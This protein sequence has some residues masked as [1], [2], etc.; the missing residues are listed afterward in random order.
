DTVAMRPN[1][2]GTKAEP[3]VLPARI[4]NLLVNGATGI[5]VGM[6]TNIPPHNLGEVCTALVKLLDNEELTTAQ[7]CRW[8][9]GPDFPTGV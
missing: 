7:L 1:F 5:A 2:D 4:P 8:I 9:K 3:V 6:A